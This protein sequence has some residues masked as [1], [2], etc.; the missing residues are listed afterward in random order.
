MIVRCAVESL[1]IRSLPLTTAATDTG[2]R[3]RMNEQAHVYGRSVRPGWLY[4]DAK[5]GAG[6]VAEAFVGEVPANA[7]LAPLQPIEPPAPLPPP[8]KPKFS[9]QGEDPELTDK[10]EKLRVLAALEGIEF[11]T[12]DF[13]GVRTQEDTAKILKYRDDDYA[14]YVKGLARRSPGRKP[15]PIN[16]WR[17]IAPFGRSYHNYGCA[18]DLKPTR[19]PPS[20]TESKA[21]ERL[22]ALAPKVG[23]R[24]ISND[25]PHVELPITL[26]AAKKRYESRTR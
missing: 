24:T 13:G 6:W 19:W 25:P 20:F 8:P 18:R 22:R 17:K 9:L 7:P 15:L 4:V 3:M 26:A 21:L 12:A 16:T 14:V 1:R 10:I 11:T 23:L 2:K 5:E